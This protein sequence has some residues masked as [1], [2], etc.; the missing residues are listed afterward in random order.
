MS[1]T[2]ALALAIAIVIVIVIRFT[3]AMRIAL[4]RRNVLT[5]SLSV[6][7]VCA[8]TQH[9]VHSE[10]NQ[11]QSSDK[12]RKHSFGNPITPEFGDYLFFPTGMIG[13]MAV[14]ALANSPTNVDRCGV[15]G[16]QLRH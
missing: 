13:S 7:M 9:R 11:R 4:V 2:L 3:V 14:R 5:T 12:L 6:R 1:A 8:A 15:V 16:D 10:R